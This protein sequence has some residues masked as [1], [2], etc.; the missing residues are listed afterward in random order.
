V[1]WRSKLPRSSHWRS[2][3]SRTSRFMIFYFLLLVGPHQVV[4]KQGWLFRQQ[5]P[6]HAHYHVFPNFLECRATSNAR[7]DAVKIPHGNEK[8][9]KKIKE[10]MKRIKSL[11]PLRPSQASQSTPTPLATTVTKKGKKLKSCWSNKNLFVPG[12]TKP[13]LTGC[14]SAQPSHKFKKHLTQPS[15]R[16]VINPC[17]A[18]MPLG[19]TCVH[20]GAREIKKRA[21]V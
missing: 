4:S 18:S 9:T 19:V 7:K 21:F 15:K 8:F 1:F 16:V 14:R 17:H 6:I 20:C 11:S 2:R 3:L 12:P 5:L 10:H 13:L